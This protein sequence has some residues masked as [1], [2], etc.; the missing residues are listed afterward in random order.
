MPEDTVLSFCDTNDRE[1]LLSI[2]GIS[3][4]VERFPD[5]AAA[6]KKVVEQQQPLSNK[7]RNLLSV[8]YKNVV[9][10]RRSSWRVISSIS[11]SE[12]GKFPVEEMRAKI[13]KELENV[14]A[15]VLTLLKKYLIPN[16]K[17]ADGQLFYWKM[18]GDYFRYLA[19]VREGSAREEA[20]NEAEAAY[21]EANKM[22]TSLPVVHP[23]RLGLA[24]N[25][26][27]FYYEIKNQ[28]EEACALARASFNE[29]IKYIDEAKDEAHKDGGLI[30][31]LLRDN[32]TLWTSDR[33]TDQ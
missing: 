25:R 5:M 6:M 19:E 23:I 20:V 24:L 15:E 4:S 16:E 1:L 33:E 3:E 27:V 12:S 22:A 30:L 11:E 13:K 28:P 21:E 7:E 9:G 2:A 18:F 26:S 31:Q 10:S 14:C 17:Q 29:G 32:L 8:A